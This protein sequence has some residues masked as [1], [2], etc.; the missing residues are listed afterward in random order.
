M[1]KQ[2]EILQNSPQNI[3]DDSNKL[4]ESDFGKCIKRKH[5]AHVVIRTLDCLTTIAEF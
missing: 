4:T 5:C 2:W 3:L 1:P